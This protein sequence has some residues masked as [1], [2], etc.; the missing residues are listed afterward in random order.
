VRT[1]PAAGGSID[2]VKGVTN[3]K[4][5]FAIELRG[6]GFVIDKTEIEPSFKET[7]NGLV[8]MCDAI[9]TQQDDRHV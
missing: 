2:Y 1:D 5:A 9:A 7:W 3:I 4:N 6:D 8:A